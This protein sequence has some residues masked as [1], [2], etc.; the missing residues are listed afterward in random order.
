LKESSDGEILITSGSRFGSSGG[1]F[2]GKTETLYTL[3]EVDWWGCARCMVLWAATTATELAVIQRGLR[4]EVFTDWMLVT[5][6]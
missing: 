6:C 3:F 1:I 4:P 2:V 5:G